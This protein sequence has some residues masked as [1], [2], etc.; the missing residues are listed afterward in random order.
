MISFNIVEDSELRKEVVFNELSS[1]DQRFLLR[2][3]YDEKRFHDCPEHIWE[4]IIEYG[5]VFLICEKCQGDYSHVLHEY[6]EHLNFSARTKSVEWI[7]EEGGNYYQP[8]YN[9]WL[10]VEVYGHDSC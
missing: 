6:Q 2:D 7:V 10:D 8:E 1:I 4:L 5:S 9:E 3:A